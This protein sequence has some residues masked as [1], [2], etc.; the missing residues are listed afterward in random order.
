MMTRRRVTRY[1]SGCR[2]GKDRGSGADAGGLRSLSERAVGCDVDCT[3]AGEWMNE[4]EMTMTILRGTVQRNTVARKRGKARW[5]KERGNHISPF[6]PKWRSGTEE[7]STTAK[8]KG[9][10]GEH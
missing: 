4:A 8:P 10:R 5:I 3:Y 6:E 1:S 9:G 2:E 7:S